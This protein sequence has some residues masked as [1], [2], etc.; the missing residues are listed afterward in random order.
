[1]SRAPQLAQLPPAVGAFIIRTRTITEAD[2]SF[3]P[4]RDTLRPQI[5]LDGSM[6]RVLRLGS[7]FAAWLLTG[8]LI[9]LRVYGME[10]PDPALSNL[11]GAE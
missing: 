1:M 2:I 7:G 11:P 9:L 6:P 3:A 8:S 4:Y 5:P 10:L